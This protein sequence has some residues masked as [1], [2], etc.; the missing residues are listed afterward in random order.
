M[1]VWNQKNLQKE[2]MEFKE[3]LIGE[4]YKYIWLIKKIGKAIYIKSLI[5]DDKIW[6][7]KFNRLLIQKST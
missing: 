2:Q 1:E 5:G 4:L 3:S 7:P 6:L